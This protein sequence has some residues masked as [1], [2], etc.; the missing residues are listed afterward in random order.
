MKQ[1][2]MLT[3]IS[4]V[5]LLFLIAACE[6]G[7][8]VGTTAKP[9]IG[10]SE[11]LE[12]GFLDGNPPEEVTDGDTFD[13]QALVRLINNGEHEF[14]DP[15]GDPEV[16]NDIKVSLIGFAP[17]DFRSE[18]GDFE[19][20]DLIDESP[21]DVPL[22]K[23]KD[24]EGN[25]LD[26]IETYITFPKDDKNFKF[27]EQIAGNTVFI[28]RANV[29]YLYQTRVVSEICVLA[30]QIYAGTDAICDPSGQKPVFS[31]GSP[32]QVTGFRQSVV[33][34]DKSQLSFDVVHQ[35]NG[36]V[37]DPSAAA[38]CPRN[39]TDRRN[40]GD[41]VRVTIKTGL[42]GNKLKCVGLDDAATQSSGIVKLVNGKRTITC[43]QEL[44]SDRSDFKKNVDITVDFNYLDR[45]D[46]EVLVKHL[47]S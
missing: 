45:A 9:F 35:G 14:S 19:D 21:I 16:V 47:I 22:A 41:K 46:K 28:F 17:G 10:G 13:F 34:T 40:K 4:F 29:C 32:V 5:V 42:T 11:G 36:K 8:V 27:K 37:F 15:S 33:G 30:N 18:D 20:S 7:D 2:R 31:S 6:E 24:S 44:D 38:D 26:S 12:I 25:I 39:P 1:K 23:R 3:L 43:T